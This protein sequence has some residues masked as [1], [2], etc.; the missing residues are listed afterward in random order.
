MWKDLWDRI[1]KAQRF[2]MKLDTYVLLHNLKHLF[3]KKWD[4]TNEFM[5]VEFQCRM[6]SLAHGWH[7]INVS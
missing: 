4:F 6:Q 2:E 5:V 7:L 3:Q 1:A